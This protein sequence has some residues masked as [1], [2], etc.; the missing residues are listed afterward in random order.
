MFEMNG[1]Y[2]VKTSKRGTEYIETEAGEPVA[3]RCTKCN[4]LKELQNNQCII[5]GIGEC[6]S[7]STRKNQ[8]SI[9]HFI[10]VDWGIAGHTYENCYFMYL[11]LNKNK[12]DTNPFEWIKTQPEAYQERFHAVFVPMLVERN[13]MT[14]KEFTAYVYECEPQA[15]DQDEE[16]GA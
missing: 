5:S 6:S 1:E 16:A 14:I 2:I 9:E 12:R 7:L 8:L 3:K 4:A 15:K 13:N 10:P 11:P